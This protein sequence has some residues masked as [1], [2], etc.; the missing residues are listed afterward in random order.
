MILPIT[1]ID[2]NVDVTKEQVKRFTWDFPTYS[3]NRLHH[4]PFAGLRLL[5]KLSKKA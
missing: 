3:V 1:H 5:L 4:K 2:R